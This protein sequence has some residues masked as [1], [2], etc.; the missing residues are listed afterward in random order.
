MKKSFYFVTFLP[1]V[2]ILSACAQASDCFREDVFCAGLVTDVLG[3]EDHGMN[4][5]TWAGLQDA[6]ASGVVDRVEYIESND[7]RDYEKNI[8]YFAEHGY[9]VIVTTGVGMS[10]ETLRAADLK[11]EAVR[12]SSSALI[13]PTKKC[14]RT[15][16]LSHLPKTKWDSLPACWRC[17]SQKPR[18]LAACVRPLALIRCG[19]IARASAPVQRLPINRQVK[20]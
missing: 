20:M 16:S 17:V 7:T 13:N 15:S 10:D 2:L 1:F 8:A 18:L 3:I 12:L 19:D 14:A 5:D 11:P 4:Q 9:D 6:K